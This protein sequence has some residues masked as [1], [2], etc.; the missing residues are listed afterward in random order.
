MTNRT[1][2][3]TLVEA[4]AQLGVSAKTL[5]NQALAGK[6]RAEKRGRDWFVTQREVDRYAKEHRRERIPA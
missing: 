1:R 5:R 6:L 2:D 4:A 3:L